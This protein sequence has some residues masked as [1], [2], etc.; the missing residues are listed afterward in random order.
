MPWLIAKAF[1]MTLK[2]KGTIQVGTEKVT[3]EFACYKINTHL[4]KSG[5]GM[6]VQ[7]QTSK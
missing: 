2:P 4:R 3:T 6:R 1:L 7:I 5:S